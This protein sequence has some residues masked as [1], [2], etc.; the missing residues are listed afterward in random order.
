MRPFDIRR[1]RTVGEVSVGEDAAL[2]CGGT[3]LLLVMKQGF[4][5]YEELVD[6][7]GIPELRE[8]SLDGDVVRIGAAVTHRELELSPLIRQ[9]LPLLSEVEHNV[10]NVRVRNV[11]TIGGNLCFAEPHSDMG[12]TAILLGGTMVTG[13]RRI[14]AE[15]FILGAYE[16][17]L[18]P[19]ELLVRLEFPVSSPR[20]AAGYQ[21][22]QFHE[23]PTAAAG[24]VLTASDD[25]RTCLSARV[26]IGA[27]GPMPKRVADAEALFAGRGWEQVL[28]DARQ[29][30]RRAA[31]ISDPIA[32]LTGS[33]EYKAHLIE[34]FVER[35]TRQAVERLQ[36]G[37]IAR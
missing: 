36:Q 13:R 32:D 31:A 2:Y 22:F 12:L 9:H 19:G 6:V 10:A 5:R 18:E 26:A 7:K 14:A 21:K 25:G 34:V 28:A 8:L 20:S 3:E 15:D 30:G 33:E 27:A 4:A 24:V 23:R 37:G 35:A 1:P 16:S 29:A 11:G 17:C